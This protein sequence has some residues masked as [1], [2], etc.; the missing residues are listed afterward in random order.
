MRPKGQPKKTATNGRKNAT[1]GTTEKD[2]YQRP[3]KCDRRDN[4]K[5]L[6][7]T[8]AKMRPKGQPATMPEKRRKNNAGLKTR[9]A[10]E[11]QGSREYAREMHKEKSRARMREI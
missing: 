6:L 3:Q 9:E 2:C 7:P 10:Y 4:R 5:R 8:A 1:E 11:K